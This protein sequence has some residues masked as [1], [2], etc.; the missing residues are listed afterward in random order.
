MPTV[1]FSKVEI[2]EA[3]RA[4][5]MFVDGSMTDFMIHTLNAGYTVKKYVNGNWSVVETAD[6]LAKAKTIA[7]KQIAA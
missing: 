5:A 7:K 1:T 6:S 2:E 4:V 3:G